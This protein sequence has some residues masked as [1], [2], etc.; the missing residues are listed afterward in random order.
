MQFK[1]TVYSAVFLI[2]PALAMEQSSYPQLGS[3]E[4]DLLSRMEIKLSKDTVLNFLT[5]KPFSRKQLVGVIQSLDSN[6]ENIA[7]TDIDRYNMENALMDNSE[8]VSGTKEGFASKKP[9]LGVFYKTRP[10]F[11]EVDQKDFYLSVNP[12][13]QLR[14]AKENGYNS[15]L[16]VNTRGVVIRGMIAR[17]LGFQTYLTDNQER[18]PQFV[19]SRINQ[20]EAVPGEGFYKH[21]KNTGVDYFDAR[22][23]LTFNAAKYLDFQF[24]Y[25]KNFIG[26]GYR[27]LVLSDNSNSYLFLR[28]NTQI[29]RLNYNVLFMELTPQFRKGGSDYLLPRKYAAVHHLSVNAP[30]WLT[31]GIF[32]AIVFGRQDHF[33]FL[34]LNPVI[35]LRAAE[36]QAGSP[37]NALA[38]IDLKANIAHSFQLYGQLMLDEFKLSELRAGNGWWGNKFGLQLGENMWMHSE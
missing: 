19:Q 5:D 22:G 38:G 18:A 36:Q 16:F 26:N 27:S 35:F 25:D 9:F 8:W 34:Y 13:L 33:D 10:D 30:K 14:A 32:D 1:K 2:F 11:F 23:Y 21:F 7:W 31:V 4:Y 28:I 24:G 29:W 3:K 17:R 12:V 20:Y 15:M 6:H 37:D